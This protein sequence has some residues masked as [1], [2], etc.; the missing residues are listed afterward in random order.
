MAGRSTGAIAL[1]LACVVAGP[2]TPAPAPGA[3]GQAL[4]DALREHV[5]GAAQPTGRHGRR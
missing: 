3:T 4:R 1:V 2:A 5:L